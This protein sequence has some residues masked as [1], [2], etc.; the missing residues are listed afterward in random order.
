MIIL[1][2]TLISNEEEFLSLH[3]HSLFLLL[4]ILHVSHSDEYVAGLVALTL[5]LWWSVRTLFIY[6]LA[7]FMKCLSWPL[8]ISVFVFYF[9]LIYGSSLCSLNT[10][11]LSVV[12]YIYL[13]PLCGLT[14]HSL[15]GV[16]GEPKLLILIQ[17]YDSSF[18]FMVWVIF[19]SY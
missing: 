18:S 1:I 14:F 4:V 5:F 3:L 13:L 19:V 16:L 6:S 8:P 2:Y 15:I 9:L 11:L 12:Y 7:S 17:F 10:R